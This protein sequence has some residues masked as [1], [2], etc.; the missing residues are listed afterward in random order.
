MDEEEFEDEDFD[1]VTETIMP[2]LRIYLSAGKEN[3]DMLDTEE[4]VE[5][6][7]ANNDSITDTIKR[8]LDKGIVNVYAC[9][10]ND[11]MK[12]LYAM[13][14]KDL[15]ITNL[16]QT[17]LAEKLGVSQPLV[18][19]WFSGKVIPRPETFRKISLATGTPVK[20]LIDY[21][22]EKNNKELE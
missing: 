22:Y 4:I 7:S 13:Q 11:T 3:H 15:L 19:K 2:F 16:T 1:G 21:I 12:V 18:S 14:K 17:E 8:L 9:S 20:E 5:W 6:L 10:F